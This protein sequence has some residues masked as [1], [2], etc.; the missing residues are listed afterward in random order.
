LFLDDFWQM[1]V[2]QRVKCIVGIFN[3][4]DL[5]KMKCPTYWPTAIKTP[6]TLSPL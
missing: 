5:K 6:M 4:Q 1:I 2:E 3:D